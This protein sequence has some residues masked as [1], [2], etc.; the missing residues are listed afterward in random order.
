M[1]SDSAMNGDSTMGGDSTTGDSGNGDSSTKP[2]ASDGGDASMTADAGDGAANDASKGPDGAD[3]SAGCGADNTKCTDNGG[4]GLCKAA[5]CAHCADPADDG[6][7]TTAY[8]SASMPYLCLAGACAPGDC[9][10]DGNCA[11]NP[12]GKICG[13]STP[14]VCGKCTADQQCAGQASGPVCNTTTGA[15]VAG[16]CAVDAGV[17]SGG[18]V[19]TCSANAADIC[20][21][22]TC[23]PGAGANACCPGPSSAMYC[24]AKLNDPHAACVNHACT[25]C[26]AVGGSTYLVDP[27]HGS[28]QTGTGDG[29]TPGC[30]FKTI[31]RALQVIGIAA[32]AVTIAVLGPS[33]VSAAVTGEAFPIALPANVTLTTTGAGMVVVDVTDATSGFTLTAPNS[34]IRGG[35]IDDAG[36]NP[37]LTINGRSGNNNAT[38]GIVVDTGAGVTP[39]NSPQI[40]NVIVTSF[41]DDGI[42]VDQAGI[43]RIGGGVTST[44]NGVPGAR[45]A[46]LHVTATGQAIIDVAAAATPTHFDD[47]TNHGIHV[48]TNGSITLT[49][50][51]IDHSTGTGTVTT[52]RNY[53]AGVWIEQTPGTP[54]LNSIH[55]LVS[56][57]N[58]NG[59][60]LRFVGG[61]NVILRGS[62]ALGNQGNGLIVSA[63]GTTGNALN[64]IS[65]IDVGSA[66]DA[67][68]TFG[69]NTFQESLGF[70]NNGG[71]GLCLNMRDTARVLQATGN[72]FRTFDCS[73]GVH[74]LTLNAG[75][76][77]NGPA[78]AG[79]VCDLGI[80][81]VTGNSIDVS[82]C[83]Q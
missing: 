55:G 77:G 51:V 38:N 24:A 40:A 62:V 70:G 61:S 1:G 78:C 29:T 36:I 22:G 19:G 28:D 66:V 67:G 56:F 72:V 14:N 63:G 74:A 39:A 21:T 18:G 83:T 5:V 10:T 76:C 12:N 68:G 79:G 2:D 31:G 32:S 75:G 25:A 16:T 34:G 65:N 47:N 58:T 57:G 35:T 60:G 52:N 49:A 53:L 23:E 46:G 80:A 81:N 37:G 20:C 6:H 3:G 13:A 41:V 27:V 30:G 4:L 50:T 26:P 33:T 7:C 45:M 82:M 59:N 43:L 42:L 71:A 64:D 11:A 44:L 54:P 15:C 73:N 48:D 17:T 69:G 9:R 8:G